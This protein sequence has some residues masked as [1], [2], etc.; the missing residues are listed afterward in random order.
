M[1]VANNRHHE[2]QVSL[3]E[4]YTKQSIKSKLLVIILDEK[5]RESKRSTREKSTNKP[6]VRKAIFR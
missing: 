4:N 2:N 5:K 1:E 6:S 3:I